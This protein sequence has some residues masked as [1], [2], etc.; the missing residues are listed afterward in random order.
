M[1]V[2][3]PDLVQLNRFQMLNLTTLRHVTIPY[4][5]LVVF[6]VFQVVTLL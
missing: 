6:N 1:K 5:K 4:R 2:A 3:T